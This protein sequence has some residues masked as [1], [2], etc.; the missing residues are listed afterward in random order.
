DAVPWQPDRK[1]SRTRG[2]W[3]RMG[4]GFEG[5]VRQGECPTAGGGGGA[6][7]AVGRGRRTGGPAAPK[8]RHGRGQQG[9]PLSDGLMGG[10]GGAPRPGPG[11]PP[12]A[13]SGFSHAGETPPV[14]GWPVTWWQ[15]LTGD[16]H[17][18]DAAQVAGPYPPRRRVGAARRARQATEA[19]MPSYVCLK[20]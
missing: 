10:G 12:A 16:G 8:K 17:A 5:T 9:P 15:R 7:F 20:C 14:R 6:G 4:R 3:R 1:A 11:I 19:V 18:D 13:A 2:R